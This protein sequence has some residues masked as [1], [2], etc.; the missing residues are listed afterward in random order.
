M[1]LNKQLFSKKPLN[2]FV[3]KDLLDNTS[4]SILVNYSGFN[5]DEN[6]AFKKFLSKYKLKVKHIKNRPLVSY[7]K[8]TNYKSI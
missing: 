6:F 1:S 2:S 7:L 5:V 3:V 8:D 4:L